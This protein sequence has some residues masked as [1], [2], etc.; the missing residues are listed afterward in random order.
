[1]SPNPLPMARVIGEGVLDEDSRVTDVT[2]LVSEYG[3]NTVRLDRKA[4]LELVDI[5]STHYL[6][7]A[8]TTNQDGVPFDSLRMS[9]IEALICDLGMVGEKDSSVLRAFLLGYFL[10][11]MKV[12]AEVSFSRPAA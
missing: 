11:H 9:V 3:G 2:Y 5:Q 10:S 8:L 4:M 1:M 6:R 12:G 7:T